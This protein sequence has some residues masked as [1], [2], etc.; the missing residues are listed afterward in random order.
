MLNNF[1]IQTILI[2]AVVLIGVLPI[3]EYAH[4]WVADK[5]GD[6]TARYSGRLTLNPMAHLD[7]VGSVLL[8][9]CGIGWAKPVPVNP[10]NFKNSRRDMALTALA[11]P[12]SNVIVALIAMIVYKILFFT[13]IL[14]NPNL[15]VLGLVFQTFIIINLSLAVFNLLPIPPLDGSKILD[16]IL[17]RSAS[18]FMYE[19]QQYITIALMICLVFGL[20]DAPIGF[21]Q[22]VLFNAIDFLTGFIDVIAKA[23]R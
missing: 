14:I 1:N 3:H 18:R 12:A 10:L 13:G 8:L 7:P 4:G 22:R 15:Y 19:Y 5:L 6:K 11:G 17:P 20:L 16:P 23:I 21:L 9:L 2:R